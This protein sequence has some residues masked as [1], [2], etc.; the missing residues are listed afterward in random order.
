MLSRRSLAA[1]AL[2]PAMPAAVA[3]A[4]DPILEAIAMADAAR[5]RWEA[6]PEQSLV[7]TVADQELDAAQDRVLATVPTSLPGIL[8]LIAFARSEGFL[9]DPTAA[10]V[11]GM[12][13]R[14]VAGMLGSRG[15][16]F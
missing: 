15:H 10:T 1:L 8:K 14:A 9:D 3:A 11:T 2:V 13:E 5:R 12:I 6:V 7:L 16:D 4:P